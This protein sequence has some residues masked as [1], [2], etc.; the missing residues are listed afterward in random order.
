MASGGSED[1]AQVRLTNLSTCWMRG[2]LLAFPPHMATPYNEGMG[3]HEYHS[4]RKF[5]ATPEPPGKLGKD[6]DA[7]TELARFKELKKADVA[8]KP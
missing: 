4:K 6:A 3:L 7:A 2:T 8:S 5:S 1:E